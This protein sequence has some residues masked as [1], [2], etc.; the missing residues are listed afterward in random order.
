M[1]HK[2]V[3]F[4]QF[5]EKKPWKVLKLS[6]VYSLTNQSSYQRLINMLW[7]TTGILPGLGIRFA[8]IAIYC[9]GIRLV[10]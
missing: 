4:A 8:V 1:T 6:K 3:I 5:K 7:I 2:V 10:K 9:I